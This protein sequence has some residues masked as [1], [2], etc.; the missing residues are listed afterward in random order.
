MRHHMRIIL[1]LSFVI[2]LSQLNPPA[3]I[4]PTPPS[5]TLERT[6][7]HTHVRTYTHWRSRKQ[8]PVGVREI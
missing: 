5:F 2:F 3:R 1:N 6:L 7:T 8:I 4:H